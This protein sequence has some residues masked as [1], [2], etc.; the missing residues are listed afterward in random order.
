MIGNWVCEQLRERHIIRYRF[1][2]YSD[3]KFDKDY[4]LFQ[5]FLNNW[6]GCDPRFKAEYDRYKDCGVRQEYRLYCTVMVKFKAYERECRY[7]DYV[8]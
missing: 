2:V 8:K 7:I 3:I 5:M 1:L 6:V 4:D